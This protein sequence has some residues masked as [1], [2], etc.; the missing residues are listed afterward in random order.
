MADQSKP[1]V[2][3]EEQLSPA[4]PLPAD[5]QASVE[6]VSTFCQGQSPRDQHN[7]FAYQLASRGYRFGAAV[8]AV[9]RTHPWACDWLQLPKEERAI[10]HALFNPTSNTEESSS[11]QQDRQ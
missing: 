4:V 5:V 3:P 10:Q 9:A 11:W 8:D 1:V 2:K 6:Y 7:A